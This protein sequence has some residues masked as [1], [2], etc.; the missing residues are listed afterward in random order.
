MSGCYGNHPEDKAREAELHRWQEEEEAAWLEKREAME[1][2]RM[3]R[4]EHERE[5]HR[6]GEK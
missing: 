6:D 4:A 3:E 1:E 5:L 2:A